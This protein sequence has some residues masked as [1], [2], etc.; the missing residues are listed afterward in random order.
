MEGGY[1]DMNINLKKKISFIR[2][3]NRYF[4]NVLGL[5]DNQILESGWSLSEVR[6]L[7]EIEKN[8]QCTSKMLAE[9]L[10]IDT[11]YLSRIIKKFDKMG[12]LTKE[13]SSKDGRAQYLYLTSKGKEIIDNLNNSSDEQIAQ[14]IKPLEVF[15]IEHLVQNMMSIETILTNGANIKLNDITIRTDIRPGDIG[16]ITYMHGCIYQEEYEYSTVFEGYVAESFFEFIHNYNAAKDRL[17]CAEHSG[18][19]IGCIGIAGHGE[20]AQLRWF[21]LDPHYRGIGLGKKLLQESLNFAKA[22][23]YK[24]IYLDTTNDLNKAIN[25]YTKA[26]FVKVSEK[27]NNSWREDLTELEFEMQL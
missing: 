1:F 25:M 11:G 9:L 24:S 12:L 5:L 6:V 13:K 26:G 16:Y 4:T 2:R 21:L 7:Y 10:C 17:W 8:D 3:F 15:D 18:K 19:I 22:K 14:L 27:P 20:R 23:N